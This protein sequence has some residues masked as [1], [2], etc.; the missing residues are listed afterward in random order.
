MEYRLSVKCDPDWTDAVS[1]RFFEIGLRGLQ[2]AAES[3]VAELVS[4]CD[5]A[6]SAHVYA[7]TISE[8]LRSLAALWPNA[9]DWS[10]DVAPLDGVDWA[11]EWKKYF[12][13]VHVSD[14]IV[15]RPSW[16]PYDA[17]PGELVIVIDPKM[18]FGTGG[19]E[20]TTLALRALERLCDECVLGPDTPI[21]D[22]G[23][24]TGIL[25]IAAVL[26]GAPRAFGVDTD[27]V[28]VECAVENAESNNVADRT[29]FVALGA[30]GVDETYRIVVANIDAP[31][32]D[33]IAPEVSARVAV[34][35]R[36]LLTGLLEAGANEI[37]SRFAALGYRAL[38]R[39]ALGE[40][41]LSE[42]E[43]QL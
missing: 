35:G 16:E 34:C 22:V 2:I 11:N 13:P 39:D 23:T 27:P 37:E 31:T 3:P 24:G 26:L 38:R 40:W 36:L 9:T 4:Y 30:E 19:H 21:F 18:A 28:A 29:R 10:V 42:M 6:D 1:N 33:V 14:R 5:R 8:Y 15:I 32:L 41:R 43:R 17:A 20:T 25:A 7:E 12:K